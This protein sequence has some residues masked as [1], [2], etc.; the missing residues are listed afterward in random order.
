MKHRNW[1]LVVI[2]TAAASVALADQTPVQVEVKCP[3]KTIE[4]NIGKHAQNMVRGS[5][6]HKLV[7]DSTATVRITLSAAP[8]S[9]KSN[10]KD[11]PLGISFAMLV[12]KKA[13]TGAWDVTA[14]QN[15][16]VPLDEI[17]TTVKD[18]VADAIK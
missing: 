1:L 9:H 12:R 10:D 4:Y 5:K 16:F 18:S 2:L 15:S 6:A 8:V 11:A 7:T 17:E 14:F 13:A 3:D